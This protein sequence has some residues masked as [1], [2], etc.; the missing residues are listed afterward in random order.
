MGPEKD[1]PQT[2]VVTTKGQVVIPARL[3]RRYGIKRGTTV[4]FMEDGLDLILRPVTDDY[5]RSLK[6]SLGTGG[7]ALKLLMEDKKRE[8]D[9]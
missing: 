7:K 3:R 8:R 5:I 4:C 1:V 6:G 9:L 2:S